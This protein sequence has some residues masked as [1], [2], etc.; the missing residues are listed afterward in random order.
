MLRLMLALGAVAFWQV[1][2]A[3]A[4]TPRVE[5]LV[6]VGFDGLSTDGVRKTASPTIKRLMRDGASTLHARAVMPTSSSPNWASMIMGAGPEQHGIDSND[7][8]RDKFAITPTARGPEG[9]FPT[10]FG[11]LRSAQPQATI[12]VFHDWS[13]F[14]RLVERKSCDVVEHPKGAAETAAR[15]A[16]Y[17]KQ[18]RPTL[19]FVHLDLVDHAGHAHGWTSPEYYQAVETGD[20]LLADLLAAIAAA[21][22]DGRTIVLVTADHGG[23]GKKHGGNTMAELEIPW[24]LAG[25]GV[26]HGHEIASPVNTFDTAA[27]IAHIFRLSPPE[28]WIARPVLEAFE[29]AIR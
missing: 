29:P 26:R 11:L 25:P 12:A 1:S 17:L 13:G 4:D 28:C 27:T 6:V 2:P 10:I 23:L 15:A 20:K 5:H 24:I 22:I 8:Q 19:L 18:H 7:W 3:W 16:D 14:G 21:G 9:I